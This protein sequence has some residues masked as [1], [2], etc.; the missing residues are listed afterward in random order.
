ML[1][2]GAI[3]H[4]NREGGAA[5]CVLPDQGHI[6]KVHRAADPTKDA[7]RAPATLPWLCSRHCHIRKR[8]GK[9]R[10]GVSRHRG[11]FAWGGAHT[12]LENNPSSV[13]HTLLTACSSFFP[14][15]IP[16]GGSKGLLGWEPLRVGMLPLV[17]TIHYSLSWRQKPQKIRFLNLNSNFLHSYQGADWLAAGVRSKPVASKPIAVPGMPV[18]IPLWH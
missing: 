10:K 1:P 13:H 18:S 5:I 14:P 8:A 17:M 12:P 11:D 4:R 16:K 6:S 15:C 2:G 9:P 7:H 3:L